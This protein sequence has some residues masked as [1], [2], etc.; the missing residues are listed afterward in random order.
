TLR[1]RATTAA[2]GG[3]H[4]L[5]I[6]YYYDAIIVRAGGASLR[7]AVGLAESGLETACISK[8]F[9]TRSYTVAAQGGINAALGNITEEIVYRLAR[10][11][12][13]NPLYDSRSTKSVYELENYRMPFSRTSK[14]TIYQRALG[15][16]SLE[17][18]N[19]GQAY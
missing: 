4:Y 6:N 2:S 18:G 7:A 1:R 8:L 16:Q 14:G 11:L 10:R 5:V 19:G 15:G 12:R 13:C 3:L 17:Y 9:P